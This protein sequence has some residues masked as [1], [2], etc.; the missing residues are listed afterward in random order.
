MIRILQS[1]ANMDRAGIETMLM[2]YYRHIDRSKVQFDFLCSNSKIGAYEDEI[3]SMGGYIHRSTG[4]N[5]LKYGEY[6]KYMK[7]LFQEHPEYKIVHAHNGAFVVYPLYA[8]KKY[9]IP[10]RISHVHS[11]A[12]TFD[13]KWFLKMVCKP[14]IKKV[15]THKY[16][17]GEAACNFY[18]GENSVRNR[19]A[20]VV[21][22]AIEIKKYIFNS[23]TRE[24][25]RL[26]YGLKD[27]VVIGHAGRFMSQ[28]NHEFLID[29]FKDLVNQN[30][31]YK[32][33][34]LGD[35]PLMNSIRKKV[36]RSGLYNNV[37]F[38]GNVN[39]TNEW[40][41]AFDLFVL[42]S[43][44]EGLPVVAIEAQTADLPCL[45]SD[46]IT[47]E[48]DITENA[49][50]LS[51]DKNVRE[52]SNMIISLTKIQKER[53]NRT[54]DIGNAGYNIEIEAKKLQDF[55]IKTYKEL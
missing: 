38:L 33:I 29:V 50:F 47:H 39:N 34:L 5:P 51:L 14:F 6:L 21:N 45:F 23:E 20:V 42:P 3:K 9:N 48:I 52:W 15:C 54:K 35:G 30:P 41:Q 2:N 28:K 37:L 1:V 44:W 16:G 25:L 22:N 46:S 32:L 27:S 49:H 43:I 36:E 10:V 17:C 31:K 19:E 7:T 24:A 18:Y 12:F 4:F 55:Y 53:V 40:Y 13:L 26:K 8:A 11:A